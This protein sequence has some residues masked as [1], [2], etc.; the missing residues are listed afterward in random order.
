MSEGGASPALRT[1]AVG[2]LPSPLSPFLSSPLSS[3]LSALASRISPLGSRLS[4]LASPLISRFP[5]PG[6]ESR[7]EPGPSS[8]LSP[9]LSPLFPHPGFESL[10]AGEKFVFR[11]QDREH[12]A[13]ACLEPTATSPLPRHLLRPIEQTLQ[14]ANELLTRTSARLRT[15]VVGMA[16]LPT[17]ARLRTLVVGMDLLRARQQG[18]K[19]L[20]SE[21]C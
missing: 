3:R 14:A 10:A 12:V 2:S 16:L 4:A 5:H 20:S 11:H 18:S 9:L 7:C 15:L 1:P 6:F 17:S 13:T 8:R 21:D 19:L